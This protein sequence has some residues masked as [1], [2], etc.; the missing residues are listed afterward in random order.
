MAV[1]LDVIGKTLGPVPFKYNQ[2]TAILYAL[3]VGAGVDELDFIYE[4]NLKV[5]PTFAVAPLMEVIFVFVKE[6]GFNLTSVLHGD[7][8]I[9]VHKPIPTAGTLQTTGGCK[10]I[11]DMGDKGALA[12]VSYET[13]DENGELVFENIAGIWDRKAG[14]FG[15]DPG[16]KPEKIVP[17]E[18]VEPDFKVEFATSPD[19]AALY[20]LSGDKNPLHI[21]PEFAKMAGLDKPIL[22]G[23]CTF[24]VAGRAIVNSVCGGDPARFKSLSARF[25]GMVWPGETLITEGWKAEE[26]KYIIRTQTGDG[27][28]VLGNALA[29]TA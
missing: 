18:G 26:G 9:I 27:R 8:K 23:L 7:Q 4:K 15:G 6:S 22:H 25:T 2:D 3:G 20:R 24:G 16:P 13:R 12:I 14:N 1:N 5:L 21:D 17:P 10:E 29:E 11:R 19:Q 28:M